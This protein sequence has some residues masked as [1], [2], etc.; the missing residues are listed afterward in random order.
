MSEVKSQVLPFV[1]LN[2][3]ATQTILGN[4]YEYNLINVSVSQTIYSQW[5]LDKLRKWWE[6][7]AFCHRAE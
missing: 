3:L 2:P 4:V 1:C 7:L 6:S 5:K